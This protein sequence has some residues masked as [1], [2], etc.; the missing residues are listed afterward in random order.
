MSTAITMDDKIDHILLKSE[1]DD[2][3]KIH[4]T[5][6][7]FEDVVEKLEKMHARTGA[8]NCDFAGK[9]FGSWNIHFKSTRLG[10]DI[11]DFEYDKESRSF[12]LDL[13]KQA[14]QRCSKVNF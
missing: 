2:E 8:L 14:I 9:Q 11:V 3:D 7:F 1:L 10:F 6:I 4:I 12:N 13:G 5:E